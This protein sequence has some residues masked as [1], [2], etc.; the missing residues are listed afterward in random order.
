MVLRPTMLTKVPIRRSI[1]LPCLSLFKTGP[2][3]V[4]PSLALARACS[5]AAPAPRGYYIRSLSCVRFYFLNSLLLQDLRS[6]PRWSR[7]PKRRLLSSW[8]RS[9]QTLCPLLDLY[10]GTVTDLPHQ[11]FMRGIRRPL[12][13]PHRTH[14]SRWR[15][16]SYP[17][18]RS[19]L[20]SQDDHVNNHLSIGIIPRPQSTLRCVKSRP[21]LAN[22]KV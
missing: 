9:R 18:L 6:R 1:G 19:F 11:H 2:R 7:V 17:Q 21:S 3:S 10:L 14:S 13:F 5:T 4:L 22:Q 15:V 8:G 20:L 16:G 12:G